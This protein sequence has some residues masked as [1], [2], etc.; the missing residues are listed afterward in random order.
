MKKLTFALTLITLVMSGISASA[1]NVDA[2]EAQ[3]A[4]AYYMSQRSVF[5]NVEVEDLQLIYQ[6]DNTYLGVPACY[7]FN[8]SDWGWIILAGNTAIAPVMGHGDNNGN[9]DINDLPDNM[10]AWIQ[11]YAS[12]IMAVQNYEADNQSSL[13]MNAGWTRLLEKTL[14]P[15]SKSG[16]HQ[17]L[18][19]LV[20]GSPAEIKWHQGNPSGNFYNGRCPKINGV[21]CVTGCVATALSQ[22]VYY[23]EY[24]IKPRYTKRYTWRGQQ[25]SLNYDTMKFDYSKMSPSLGTNSSDSKKNEISKL[26]YA[27]GVCMEITYNTAANG[28]SGAYSG[29]VV[30]YMYNNFKY[31]RCSQIFRE[32]AGDESFVNQIRSELKLNR[33]V[34]MSGSSSTGTGND[35]AGHAWVCCGY[36]DDDE[37]QYYMNW[38]WGNSS[39]GWYDLK[40]NGSGM[41]I[42]SDP[43]NHGYTFDLGQTAMVGLVPPH[44]DSTSIDFAGHSGITPTS[45]TAAMR[46]AYPNPATH[47]VTLPCPTTH[48]TE[49]VIYSIEGKMVKTQ[50]VN[51]DDHVVVNVEGMPAGI[52]L[53][54]VGSASGKFVV[55]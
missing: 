29:N 39:N 27:I 18:T 24:P 53:Y 35:R 17:L 23:Y 21:N 43:Y 25:L 3:K 54:R 15:A 19:K 38:G 40:N 11:S 1:R 28:G 33:P 26:C 49:A 47:N 16:Q 20:Y 37:T 9:L 2:N 55:K 8:V 52:Y 31:N 36:D 45:E 22:I 34:Y 30:Q 51:G 12:K 13:K 46:M 14:K 5:P 44:A 50:P 7:F 41:Y 32:T 4:A 6:I 48:A 10:M 42:G